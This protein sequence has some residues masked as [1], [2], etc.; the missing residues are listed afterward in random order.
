MSVA[1][2]NLWTA[3]RPSPEDSDSASFK[4]KEKNLS[5]VKKIK[6]FKLIDKDICDKIIYA[7]E[8]YEEARLNYINKH[9]K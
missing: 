9:R 8:V 3:L 5:G 4:R 2:F 7:Q 6:L 1:Q